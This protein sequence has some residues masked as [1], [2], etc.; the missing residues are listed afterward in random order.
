MN[1]GYLILII[2]LLSDMFITYKK[3]NNIIRFIIKLLLLS[4]V[5]ISTLVYK[6]P[7][8]IAS[9]MLLVNTVINRYIIKDKLEDCFIG[10]KGSLFIYSILRYLKVLSLETSI[11]FLACNLY[12]LVLYVLNKNKHARIINALLLLVIMVLG[13]LYVSNDILYSYIN[14]VLYFVDFY[15]LYTNSKHPKIYNLLFVLVTIYSGVNSLLL[16]S[17]RYIILSVVMFAFFITITRRNK[18]VLCT[19]L[20]AYFLT[21]MYYFVFTIESYN[22]VYILSVIMCLICLV[23][24]YK[25]VLKKY[26]E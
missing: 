6:L 21:S 15:I 12:I 23:I 24:F 1:I 22:T 13:E 5:I 11:I 8:N 20:L 17:S 25:E 19:S 26:H 3:F 14:L 2:L 9:C 7:Y 4:G 10:I 18:F 16:L